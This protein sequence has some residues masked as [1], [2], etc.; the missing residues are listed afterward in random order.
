MV[1]PAYDLIVKNRPGEPVRAFIKRW[2]DVALGKNGRGHMVS[3]HFEKCYTPFWRLNIPRWDSQF[4]DLLKL[5]IGKD[6]YT[7]FGSYYYFT[8]QEQ[9]LM[10][11][12]LMV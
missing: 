3:S 7:W 9:M 11:R 8:T 4:Q 5:H 1:R 12:F 10:A 2:E 6:Q